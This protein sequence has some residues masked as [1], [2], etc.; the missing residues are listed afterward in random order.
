LNAT[1]NAKARSREGYSWFS[2]RLG[3]FALVVLVAV[4]KIATFAGIA[5]F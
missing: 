3:A 2:L 1:A 5:P 4:F